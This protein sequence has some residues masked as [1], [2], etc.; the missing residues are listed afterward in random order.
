MKAFIK[1]TMKI[2]AGM[3]MTVGVLGA[4][5]AL[6]HPIWSVILLGYTLFHWKHVKA[7]AEKA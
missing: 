7:Y 4:V 6:T 2:A 5:G 3:L 1:Q